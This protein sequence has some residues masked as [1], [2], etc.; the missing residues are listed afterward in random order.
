MT[1]L[2]VQTRVDALQ[3]ELKQTRD[4]AKTDKDA[5]DAA[6]ERMQASTKEQVDA[7]KREAK[8][9]E[10]LHETEMQA[11]RKSLV[12]GSMRRHS[13]T[14]THWR[15]PTRRGCTQHA[16]H[17]CTPQRS[18]IPRLRPCNAVMG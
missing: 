7:V 6:M 13:L 18:A 16:M 3:A 15:T 8:Q 17:H 4:R 11:L 2:L 10:E 1:T 12:S 9:R 5:H 14:R